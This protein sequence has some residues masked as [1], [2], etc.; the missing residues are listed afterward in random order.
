MKL[1]KDTERLV[2]VGRTGSGKT[3]A[4]LYHLSLRDYDEKP[5][6]VL[7]YK[8]DEWINKIPYAEHREM[9]EPAP[10][11]PGVYI[12]HPVL[13]QHDSEI[14]EL[15]R[16][17]NANENTGLY[18]DEGYSIDKKNKQWNKILTQGR[19]KHIPVITLSQRPVWMSRFV[20]SEADYIQVFH[21]T[22]AE[23]RKTVERYLPK[24]DNGQIKRLPEY[25]SYYYEVKADKL[26]ELAPVPSPDKIMAVFAER[27][28]P[29]IEMYE[30]EPA[31]VRG[32]K[33]VKVL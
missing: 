23:D 17:I 26:V 33:L 11:E 30:P 2:I 22:D 32:Q 28:Q 27:L 5:W 18:V 31:M 1:A 13:E 9:G 10:T 12:Y 15:M 19:S 3:I 8:G 14:V 25:H 20:M 16:Q 29:E 6:V 24:E 4:A 21:L 7:D